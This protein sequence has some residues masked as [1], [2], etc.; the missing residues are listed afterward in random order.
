MRRD[1]HHRGTSRGRK[2]GL[3]A[4]L[5]L[6]LTLEATP[7]RAEE[8][9]MPSSAAEA[10]KALE[11]RRKDLE[12]T[13]KRGREIASDVDAMAKE[14]EELKKRLI[15]TAAL[16][17]QSE[18]QMSAIEQRLTS[19]GADEQKIRASL[20]S[21]E[22][23]I[24]KLLAAL[25]RMGRNPPPVMITRR[26]DALKMVRSAMLLATAFPELRKGAAEL[27]EKLDGLMKVMADQRAESDKL[28]AEAERHT[29][30]RTRL[31][32]LLETK[33]KSLTD[34]QGE[35]AKV[36]QAAAEYSKSVTDLNELIGKL[37]AEVAKDPKV[38]EY[39]KKSAAEVAAVMP[40]PDVAKPPDQPAETPEKPATEPKMKGPVVELAP[41]GGGLAPGSAGRIEPAIP[42]QLAKGKLPLPAQGR[43]V[44]SYGDKTQLGGTS[45]GIVIET[46]FEARITSP[47][48]GWV[49]YAGEF[50][51]YGQ[52]LII[53]AGGGYHVLVA[54]MSEI[55]V[56][57]GQFVL[58]AEPIG[59]MNGPPRTAQLAVQ[60]AG[61]GV[62][63][64]TAAASSPILYVE[65]R[66]DSQPVD[67][68]P[69]WV[70]STKKVQD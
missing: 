19:L 40:P 26:E 49:V 25:Q 48:D 35:L 44:L 3:A 20:S 64:G 51:S 65:F 38:A 70:A 2:R 67:P 36:R 6:G 32:S 29:V 34:R 22:G 21:R 63:Q 41:T 66:K 11:T 15:E 23:Q 59:A 56:Q 58:A 13:E 24:A 45:K 69:W 33:N 4:A 54:G 50:R 16:E 27:T 17:Q 47:C 18:A 10:E 68:D 37:G 7:P 53:N 52:L 60:G 62:S 12:A 46:R 39:D 5:L 61:M 1:H 57:P 8:T 55:N 42:F 31:A 14:R 43:R 28:K 9:P 30:A